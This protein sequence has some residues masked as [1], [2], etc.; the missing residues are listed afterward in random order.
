MVFVIDMTVPHDL[1]AGA[2]E[3]LKIGARLAISRSSDFGVVW[4]A[5]TTLDTYVLLCLFQSIRLGIL[6][7]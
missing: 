5:P 6:L 7:Y 2:F 3:R 4:K 1:D